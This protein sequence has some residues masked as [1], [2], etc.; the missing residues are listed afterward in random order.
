MDQKFHEAYLITGTNLGNRWANIERAASEIEQHTGTILRRSSI[1]ETE[2]WG[3][4]DQ[5]GFYNQVLQIATLLQ[6][7]ELL[8][9]TLLIEEKMGRIRAERYGARIIDIDILFFDDLIMNTAQLTIPHPR[10]A[11]RNFVLAPLAET[12]P[13]LVHPQ[14]HQTITALWKASVDQLGVKKIARNVR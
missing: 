10:I 1:F 2:P 4:T 11:E 7:E 5:P 12:A 13:H 3:I 9:K 6:P 8:A 14:L